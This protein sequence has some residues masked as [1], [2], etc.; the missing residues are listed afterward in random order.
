M[1]VE[2]E[3]GKTTTKQNP[4]AHPAEQKTVASRGKKEEE[5]EGG[6]KKFSPKVSSPAL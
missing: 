6:E 1:R 2:G 3:E 5:E 4:L